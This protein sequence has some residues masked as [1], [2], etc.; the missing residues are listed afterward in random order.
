MKLKIALIGA[1]AIAAAALSACGDHNSEAS[2]PTPPPSMP[3]SQQLDT[4]QVL[5]LAQKS[6]EVSTPFEVDAGMLTLTDTSDS[7]EAI[8]VNGM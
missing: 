6:S 2:M 8:S 7:A 4:A 3:T 1:A 5:A